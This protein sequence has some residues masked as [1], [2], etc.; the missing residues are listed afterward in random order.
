MQRR[1][2]VKFKGRKVQK[3]ERD[4]KRTSRSKEPGIRDHGDRVGSLKLKSKR[5]VWK[6][7]TNRYKY[8]VF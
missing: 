7:S 8:Q 2:Q 5:W 1:A 6:L 4:G 3:T